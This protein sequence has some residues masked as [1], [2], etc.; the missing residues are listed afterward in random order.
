M[1]EK[2]NKSVELIVSDMKEHKI[3]SLQ[4]LYKYCQNFS[5]L[6]KEKYNIKEKNISKWFLPDCFDEQDVMIDEQDVM[7]NIQDLIQSHNRTIDDWSDLEDSISKP[8]VTIKSFQFKEILFNKKHFN[9]IVKD[10]NLNLKFNEFVDYF[11]EKNIKDLNFDRKSLPMNDIFLIHFNKEFKKTEKLKLSFMYHM[12]KEEILDEKIAFLS[13]SKS[14]EKGILEKNLIDWSLKNTENHISKIV[15]FIMLVNVFSAN[16]FVEKEGF[17]NLLKKNLDVSE[18]EK[19]YNIYLDFKECSIENKENY[20][21]LKHKDLT[22]ND[23]NEIV[24]II[25]D[26]IEENDFFMSKEKKKPHINYN[27]KSF[28]IFFDEHKQHRQDLYFNIFK[29]Y[30]KHDINKLN[31]E[32][33]ILIIKNKIDEYKIL[34]E[35]KMNE[36]YQENNKPVI[37]L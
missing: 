34:N 28:I 2:L 32:E 5:E 19:K 6:K 14:I 7:N 11:I 22:K 35:I 36:S 8:S 20:I 12:I 27:K 18:I 1:N 29:Q 30:I 16:Y 10:L 3:S 33:K 24:T 26:T 25:N 37:K 9:Q 23:I 15:Q 4:D 21:L 13:L 17:W 31:L